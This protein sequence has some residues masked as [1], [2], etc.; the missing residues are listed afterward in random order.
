[1]P[2][3]YDDGSKQFGADLATNAQTLN[4]VEA[5][6]RAGDHARATQ[7]AEAALARGVEHPMLL[8]LRAARLDGEGRTEQAIADIRRAFE[9]KPWDYTI[10]NMLGMYLAKVGRRGEAMAAFDEAVRIEPTYAQAH[11]SKGWVAE[12]AGDFDTAVAAHER[13]VAAQPKFPEALASLAAI[14]SLRSEWDRARDH[15]GRALALDSGQPTAAVA[16][17]AV[18]LT[19]GAYE[20]AEKRLRALLDATP[21]RLTPHARGVALGR[22]A[23]ALDGQGK[24]KEAFAAYAEEKAQVRTLHAPRFAGH[25]TGA[26]LDAMIAAL[27]KIEDWPRPDIDGASGRASAEHVFLVGFPRSGTT[28][29]EQVLASHPDVVTLDEREVLAEPA[30]AYLSSP[31]GLARLE[32]LGPDEISRM[33]GDY[34]R[35]VREYGVAPEGK[36]FIDKLPLNTLKLPLISRLFPKAKVLFAL[37]DPRDGVLSCLRQH[38]DI[39]A[40]MF[41]LLTLDGAAAFYDRVM[42]VAAVSREK[43]P[44]DVHEHRYEALVEDFDAETRAVCA[45]VGLEWSAA[46]RDFAETAKGRDIRTPSAV[47]VRRGL[48]GQG[49]GQWRAY[50]EELAPALPVLAPWVERFGYPAA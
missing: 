7:M 44:L 8:S 24:A 1:M 43:L 45:F 33:R 21:S 34:W 15:A 10:P 42:Q 38:F 39:N 20:A 6:V 16:M 32:K 25:D 23:D 5:A 50:A 3:V 14:A 49:V 46:M 40:A 4:D 37:R 13:A 12:Q 27:N 47:Q 26:M 29:L 35:R 11:Y 48:Y 36:V 22:L 41:E 9:I 19:E 2:M 18:E 30:Q 17:A 28:L 31:D